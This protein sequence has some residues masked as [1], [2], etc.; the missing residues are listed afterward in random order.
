MAD[1]RHEDRDAEHE[2]G[3]A[4]LVVEGLNP[5]ERIVTGAAY[6]VRLASLSTSVPAHGHEH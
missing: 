3:H 6:H 4:V 1:R 2:P 5:G